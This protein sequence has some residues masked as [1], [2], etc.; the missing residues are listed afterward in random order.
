MSPKPSAEPERR[1]TRIANPARLWPFSCRL[2]CVS[3]TCSRFWVGVSVGF[4][5][6]LD[7]RE[8]HHDRSEEIPGRILYDRLTHARALVDLLRVVQ[9]SQLEMSLALHRIH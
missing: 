2:Q 8:D 1:R 9:A 4:N 3:P 7:D 5:A 6:Q